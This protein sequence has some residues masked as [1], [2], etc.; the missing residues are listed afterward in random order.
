MQDTPSVHWIAYAM[1][2]DPCP[3]SKISTSCSYDIALLNPDTGATR[4]LNVGRVYS[5]LLE[6]SHDY[7]MLLFGRDGNL[8][9]INVASDETV[10]LTQDSTDFPRYPTW[11]P[12]DNRIAYLGY[13]ETVDDLGYKVHGFITNGN[14]SMPL[15]SLQTSLSLGT[16]LNW[17]PDG[18]Y[19]VFMT[20]T[21]TTLSVFKMR[22]NGSD[23]K[24]LTDVQVFAYEPVWSPDGQKITFIA[25]IDY[26]NELFV[27]DL[28]T[29]A[30]EQVTNHHG[31]MIPARWL[32]DSQHLVYTATAPAD[33]SY[34]TYRMVNITSHRDYLI[35]DEVGV[36]YDI[37]PDGTELVYHPYGERRMCIQAIFNTS[38]RRAAL[39]IFLSQIKMP[40]QHGALDKKCRELKTH[41][42]QLPVS[43]SIG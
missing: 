6:W 29:N 19:F 8:Y 15:Y 43:R 5:D 1:N 23:L 16:P 14:N 24:A 31:N 4:V 33:T 41:G 30:I 27:I 21:V 12:V 34:S 25:N 20:P 37:S 9:T 11:S 42:Y 38:N 36:G 35:S 28:S 26:F 2:A 40:F 17:S 3:D 39:R 10:Q 22:S 18:Q 13:E 32:P 7:Q